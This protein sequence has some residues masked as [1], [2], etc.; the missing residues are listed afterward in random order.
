MMET[1][2]YELHVINECCPIHIQVLCKGE[3]D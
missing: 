3:M 1:F 2:A